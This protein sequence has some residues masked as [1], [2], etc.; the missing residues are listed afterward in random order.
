ML[1]LFLYKTSPSIWPQLLVSA[2]ESCSGSS[3]STTDNLPYH[4][5]DYNYNYD[6]NIYLLLMKIQCTEDIFV[7]TA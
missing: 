6:K 3:G 5:Y 1:C 7:V 4:Y 2:S